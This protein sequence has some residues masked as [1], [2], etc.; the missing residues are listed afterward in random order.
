MEFPLYRVPIGLGQNTDRSG[1]RI[2]GQEE[3][4]TAIVILQQRCDLSLLKTLDGHEA[5]GRLPAIWDSILEARKNPIYW[6]IEHPPFV[7]L[8]MDQNRVVHRLEY[9]EGRG[10]HVVLVDEFRSAEWLK[11]QLPPTYQPK[12]ESPIYKAGLERYC[13]RSKQYSEPLP[14]DIQPFYCYPIDSGH[15]ILAVIRNI[16][17][18]D[19]SDPWGYVVPVPVKTILRVGWEMIEGLPWVVVPYD[20]DLGLMAPDED[21][22][23]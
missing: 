2:T 21:T 20:Q 7:I 14:E 1:S 12:T 6:A 16:Y 5:V 10:G 18:G 17:P 13:D 15:S 4:H 19:A 3:T 23:F 8:T 22:E 11:E 9:Y